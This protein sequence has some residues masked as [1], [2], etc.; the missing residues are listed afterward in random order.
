MT[1]IVRLMVVGIGLL[2][3][4]PAAV[5]VVTASKPPSDIPLF[6]WFG[7]AAGAGL[8]SDGRQVAVT[9]NGITTTADYA[10][11]VENVL[12]VIQGSGNFRL[13]MQNNTRRLATRSVCV[14]FGT[15]LNGVSLQPLPVSYECVNIEEPMHA[16]ATGDVPIQNLLLNQQVDKLTRFAWTES[17]YRWRI[18]YGTDMNQDG[19]LDSPPVVVG[20]IDAASP[21]QPCAKWLMTPKDP[22]GA[23]ALFRFKILRSGEGP[24]EFV[25]NVA[26]PFSM[27]FTRQ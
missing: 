4:A 6:V 1:R 16:Y 19:I 11:G 23:A 2:A 14:D 7:N 24:A 20:C 22:S 18:G 15:Q 12:A 10:N 25:T 26:M 13:N 3:L 21:A 27:T 8:T 5:D 9:I 17:G